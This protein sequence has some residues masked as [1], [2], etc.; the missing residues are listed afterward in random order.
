VTSERIKSYDDLHLKKS[1]LF[2]EQA[3]RELQAG[4]NLLGDAVKVTLGPLGSAVVLERA[5]EPPLITHDGFTAAANLTLASPHRNLG[6]QFLCQAAAATQ[7]KVGDGSTTT[8]VLAQAILNEGFK[9]IAAGANPIFFRRGLLKGATAARAAL[10][11]LSQPLKTTA[12]MVNLAALAAGDAEIGA[13]ICHL[14]AT[15]G[16]DGIIWMHDYDG[17]DLTVELAQGMS[18]K[19]GY[20]SSSFV[21]NQTTDEAIIEDVP[22]LVADLKISQADQLIPIMDQ[23]MQAGRPRLL[24]VA[25]AVGGS[26][27]AALVV[28]HQRGQ[29][30]CLAVK[31]PAYDLQRRAMLSDLAILTGATLFN[32]ELGRPLQTAT[33]A[34]LGQLDRAIA[35]HNRTSLSGG[36]GFPAAI[37]TRLREI[38]TLMAQTEAQLDR[39]KLQ[40][41]LAALAGGFATIR[42]GGYSA[43]HR[44]ERQRLLRKTFSSVRGAIEEG[45]LPGGGVALLN[46]IPTLAAVKPANG[47]EAAAL[48][49]LQK[50]FETPLRQLAANAGQDA[51]AILGEVW[52][53]QQVT[54]NPFMGY[55]ILSQACGDLRQWGV[56]DPTPVVRAAVL[57]AISAAA[58]ILTIEASVGVVPGQP[59]SLA[60]PPSETLLRL[61][62]ERKGQRERYR[63]LGRQ[64]PPRR[65]W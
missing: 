45:V 8:I 13:L 55:N 35:T 47:D 31:P 30:K 48:R 10:N 33:L 7:D 39:D 57:N 44:Q 22:V 27:L 6:V 26:A 46:I 42:V 61:Q 63:R 17:V 11:K 38:Q 54:R 9:N 64:K 14:V 24:I 51:G 3:R 60:D 65:V 12:E 4:I 29:F 19:Q 34:D 28:N 50:A 37:Q 15:L 21:T 18:W 5:G 16:K 32:V 23:L 20:L 59:I 56:L 40:Q 53:L 41:R 43:A 49:S 1:I 62:A 36:R 2:S 25:E 52:H 58:T